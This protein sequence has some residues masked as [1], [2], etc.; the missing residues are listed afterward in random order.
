MF[1]TQKGEIREFLEGGEEQGKKLALGYYFLLL[2]QLGS[3]SCLSS[4]SNLSWFCTRKSTVCWSCPF[5]GF[6]METTELQSVLQQAIE[7]PV[8]TNSFPALSSPACQSTFCSLSFQSLAV[9]PEGK[10]L[11]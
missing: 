1:K 6:N 5:L 3:S 9:L 11:A 2:I 10:G 7:L 8:E 4:F